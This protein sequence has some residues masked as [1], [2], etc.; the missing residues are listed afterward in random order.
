MPTATRAPTSAPSTGGT[1]K[2][3]DSTDGVSNIAANLL[4]TDTVEARADKANPTQLETSDFLLAGF[5]LSLIPSSARIASVS[6]NITSRDVSTVT[7]D[8]EYSTVQWRAAGTLVGTNNGGG[9]FLPDASTEY[10]FNL[11]T[12]TSAQLKASGST[13]LAIR[14][15]CIAAA[16]ADAKARLDKVELVVVFTAGGIR[17]RVRSFGRAR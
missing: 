1:W 17:T 5:D 15:V 12:L 10:K 2:W 7:N 8:L 9:A 14:V 16:K 11:G 13:G 3:L 4:S 6:A